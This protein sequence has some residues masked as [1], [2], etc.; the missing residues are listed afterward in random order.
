MLA[1]SALLFPGNG[2]A[3]D[4]A[5]QTVALDTCLQQAQASLPEQVTTA[6][7]RIDG[8]PRKL[9]ALGWYLRVRNPERRWSWTDA[10]ISAYQGSPEQLQAQDALARVQA[11]FSELNPGYTLYVNT[12]VRSLDTQ[13]ARWNTNASVGV[14]ADTLAQ[15]AGVACTLDA[16]RFARWLKRWRPPVPAHLAAPGLSAHGQAR[17]FDFQVRQGDRIVAG[18]DSRTIDTV[19]KADGWAERLAQAIKQAGPAFDGPLRSP[20]EPWH[21]AFHPQRVPRKDS[22]EAGMREQDGSAQPPIGGSAEAIHGS[23]CG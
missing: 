2:H 9:L 4:Q 5:T 16:S 6:L 12:K 3:Q 23:D 19:W 1:A 14:A 18:T 10:R 21:Y 8:T 20:R 17:A 13:L 11:R 15:A 7:D 22:P